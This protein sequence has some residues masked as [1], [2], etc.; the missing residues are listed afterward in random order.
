[1]AQSAYDNVW[2][3]DPREY[4]GGQ[5]S[6]SFFFRSLSDSYKNLFSGK[7]SNKKPVINL[8]WLEFFGEGYLPLPRSKPKMEPE[9]FI[10]KLSDDVYLHYKGHGTG[11]FNAAFEIHMGQE[12]FGTILAHPRSR[13]QGMNEKSFQLKIE[14]H[15]L[16]T[17]YWLDMLNHFTFLLDLELKSVTRCD[18]AIDGVEGVEAMLNLYYKQSSENKYINMH[19]RA[20]FTPHSINAKSMTAK[21]FS[22][23]SGKSEKIVSVYCKSDEIE[24]SNKSYIR[25]FWERS[26]LQTELNSKVHR[27]EMRFRS[28]ALKMIKDFDYEKLID[29]EYLSS[30]VKTGCKGFFEF[31]WNNNARLDRQSKIHLIPWDLLGGTL[32]E[33]NRKPEVSDR[34]KA[35]LSIHLSEKLILRQKI[36]HA[37]LEAGMRHHINFLVHF[38]ELEDWYKRKV[39]EWREDY[40][41]LVPARR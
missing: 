7:K 3:V 17:D 41:S 39:E 15:M 2:K 10:H 22:I 31:S 20:K 40:K 28:K 37:E 29:K 13:K 6:T 1:M 21:S 19:G 26:G 38:Y 5:L 27:I 9:D 34:Y 16:Y 32:L 4:N 8:D 18:I 12:V 23:G 30:L 33:K 36:R 24:I 25:S 14:N 11:F 35:K